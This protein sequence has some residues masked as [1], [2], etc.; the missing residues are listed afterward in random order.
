[1]TTGGVLFVITVV[2][3]GVALIALSIREAIRNV[4]EGR[5]FPRLSHRDMILGPTALSVYGV[6]LICVAIIFSL[7]LRH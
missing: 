2:V 6:M 1:M 4:T 5:R 3:A 7:A